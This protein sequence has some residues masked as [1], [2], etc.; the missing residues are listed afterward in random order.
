MKK[1]QPQT[2]EEYKAYVSALEAENGTLEDKN[3]ELTE[4]NK[5]LAERNRELFNSAM[6]GNGQRTE[7]KVR[8]FER[9]IDRLKFDKDEKKEG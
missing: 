9:P 2:L 7:E 8:K 6:S 1:M 3:K 5:T 4:T